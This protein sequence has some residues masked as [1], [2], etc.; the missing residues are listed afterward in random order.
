MYIVRDGA[1]LKLFV[2]MPEKDRIGF[3]WSEPHRMMYLDKNLYPEIKEGDDPVEMTLEY[4]VPAMTGIKCPECKFE[5][6]IDDRDIVDGVVKCP[7]C[8]GEII[9][10]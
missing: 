9:L 6:F 3:W 2:N 7:D 4:A 1:G 5:G 8:G 10:L